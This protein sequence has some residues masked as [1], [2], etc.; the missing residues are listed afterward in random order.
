MKKF[1]KKMKY[2]KNKL[3]LLIRILQLESNPRTLLESLS[4]KDFEY[5]LDDS[6]DADEIDYAD[7]SGEVRALIEGC[8]VPSKFRTCVELAEKLTAGIRG[9]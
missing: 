5:L 7:Y 4:L 6:V 3:A 8:G 1:L 9:E 2:K